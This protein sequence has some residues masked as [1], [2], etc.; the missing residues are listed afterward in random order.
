MDQ[1]F[2]TRRYRKLVTLLY[3]LICKFR[4][5]RDTFLFK[6]YLRTRTERDPYEFGYSYPFLFLVYTTFLYYIYIFVC[7]FLFDAEGSFYSILFV[8][9]LFYCSKDRVN[10]LSIFTYIHHVQQL[11][12]PLG[13]KPEKPSTRVQLHTAICYRRNITY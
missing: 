3:F 8:Q 12:I 13:R 2:H 6:I 7:I 4:I 10:N 9:K 5:V 11:L 1:I